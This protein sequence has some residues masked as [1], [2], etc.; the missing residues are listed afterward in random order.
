[1]ASNPLLDNIRIEPTP[2]PTALVIFGASGDL[3]PAQA[4]AR[5][6]PTVARPA[7]A[8]A[9]YGDRRRADAAVGRGIPPAVPRQPARVRRRRCREGRRGAFARVAADLPV[10]GDGRSGA[11][12]IA[13]AAA[14][15]SAASEGSALLPRDPAVGVRHR[16][17]ATSATTGL[18]RSEDG[19]AADHRREAVRHRSGDSAARSTRR[20]TSIS[21]KP[22]SSASITISARRPSRTCWSSV[23]PTACS[24]RSGIAATSTTFRSRPRKP[25]ASS[26]APSTTRVQARCATWCRI[27]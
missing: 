16:R 10:R 6:L 27:T 5:D 8:G 1:M 9:I 26:G 25:S 7:A 23:S 15:G 18:P 24:S 2:G 17:R 19:M 14:G 22:R 3:D 4:A 11:L 21:K 13:D 12:R 20:S